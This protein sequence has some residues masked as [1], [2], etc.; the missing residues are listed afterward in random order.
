MVGRQAKKQR[1]I[2]EYKLRG[3]GERQT[4]VLLSAIPLYYDYLNFSII[5]TAILN[6]CS[7]VALP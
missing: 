5:A 6:A 7:L 2:R 4:E 3:K 1:S